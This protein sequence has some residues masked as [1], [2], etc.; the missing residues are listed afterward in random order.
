LIQDPEGKRMRQRPLA[1][2]ER[3]F[4]QS[5][6][7]CE[8]Q[9]VGIQDGN[10]HHRRAQ[11]PGGELR[12]PIIRRLR[13]SFEESGAAE[14]GKAGWIGEWYA[15]E[16]GRALRSRGWRKTLLTLVRAARPGLLHSDISGQ[17][18]SGHPV[19]AENSL[20]MS[21]ILALDQ[22]TT[23]CRAIVFDE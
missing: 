16:R 5:R 9:T 11:N 8:Q 23:S 17:P 1:A 10:A 22:G 6:A 4:R 12:Q 15:W 13:A 7:A 20:P 3:A 18:S 2:G 21:Y 19:A 14:P